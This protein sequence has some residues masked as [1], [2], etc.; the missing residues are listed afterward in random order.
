MGEYFILFYSG[1]FIRPLGRCGD[2]ATFFSFSGPIGAE[3]VHVSLCV[4]RRI[5]F[6]KKYTFFFCII[7]YISLL[8]GSREQEQV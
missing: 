8:C 5:D 3:E 4:N 6:V 2:Q 1:L 7:V